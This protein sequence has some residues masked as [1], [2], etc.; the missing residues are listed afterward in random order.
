MEK[1]YIWIV[2]LVVFVLLVSLDFIKEYWEDI[3]DS[4]IKIFGVLVICILVMAIIVGIGY[5]IH[6]GW[7]FSH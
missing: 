2:C 3:R 5:L 1:N 7:N 6:I 4:L